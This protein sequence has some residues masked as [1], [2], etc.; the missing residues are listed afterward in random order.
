MGCAL[1]WMDGKLSASGAEEQNQGSQPRSQ[2]SLACCLY[3]NHG[4]TRA[5]QACAWPRGEPFS[6]CFSVSPLATLAVSTGR[7]WQGPH[8]L[9]M[10]VINSVI[11]KPLWFP[12]VR[13]FLSSCSS[14]WHCR[15]EIHQ[16]TFC[17]RHKQW[18]I[19]VKPS[20]HS[21]STLYRRQ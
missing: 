15:S 18:L 13:V 6:W 4:P 3:G 20:R 16:P 7:P 21:C 10:Q 5:G 14:C 8:T 17:S 19:S 1:P 9:R 2:G 11:I 12:E